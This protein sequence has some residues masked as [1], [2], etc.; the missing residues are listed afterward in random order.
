MAKG[1]TLGTAFTIGMPYV[2]LAYYSNLQSEEGITTLK[3]LGLDPRLL[4]ISIGIE[5][6][7][8]VIAV[9]ENLKNRIVAIKT[10]KNLVN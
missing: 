5:P 7:E 2:Y 6:V 8:T 1:A 10:D 9:F 3:N 4:R